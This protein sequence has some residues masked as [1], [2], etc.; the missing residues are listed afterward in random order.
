MSASEISLQMCNF[1]EIKLVHAFWGKIQEKCQFPCENVASVEVV[2]GE[3]IFSGKHNKLYSKIRTGF[4]GR[5]TVP[6]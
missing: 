6:V 3:V 5:K 4:A 2:F 1:T